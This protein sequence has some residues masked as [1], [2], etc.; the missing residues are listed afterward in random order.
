MNEIHSQLESKY[1]PRWLASLLREAINDHAVVVLTGARQVGKSTLL[2]QESP[3]AEWRYLTFDDLDWKR[4]GLRLGMG[5]QINR[6]RSQTLK[7]ANPAPL[8]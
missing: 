1:K 4:S 2:R 7:H 6:R 3:F 8:P 5:A